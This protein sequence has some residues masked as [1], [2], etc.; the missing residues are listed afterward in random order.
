MP[1]NAPRRVYTVRHLGELLRDGHNILL[2]DMNEKDAFGRIF[3]LA[4]LKNAGVHQGALLSLLERRIADHF[5]DLSRLDLS[6]KTLA[7]FAKLCDRA[8]GELQ[9]LRAYIAEWRTKYGTDPRPNGI[10]KNVL[11]RR[12]QVRHLLRKLERLSEYHGFS[13]QSPPERRTPQK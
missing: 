7:E 2:D 6:R 3:A 13:S 4:C 12:K 5:V 8:E 9:R 11:I 1:E 10:L